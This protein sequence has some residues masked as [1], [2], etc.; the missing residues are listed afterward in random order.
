MGR[1]RAPGHEGALPT[2]G[3]IHQVRIHRPQSRSHLP[4]PLGPQIFFI[5]RSLNS[6]PGLER[7]YPRTIY[8]RLFRGHPLFYSASREIVKSNRS[9]CRSACYCISIFPEGVEVT[10]FIGL[11][12]FDGFNGASVISRKSSRRHPSGWEIV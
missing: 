10:L 11:I 3:G 2:H 7:A 12:Y 9:P 5:S 6:R 1:H 4:L 8:Y